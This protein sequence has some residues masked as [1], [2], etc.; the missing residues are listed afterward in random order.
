[1]PKETLHYS[2]LLPD[3]VRDSAR[4]RLALT[5]RSAHPDKNNE[6][7]EFLGD[8]VLGLAVADW[9]YRNHPEWSEGDM[10]RI[11]STL[12]NREALNAVGQRTGLIDHI[13]VSGSMTDEQSPI[14]SRVVASAVEAVIGAVYLECGERQARD[15][16]LAW[17]APLLEAVPDDPE[18]AKDP[19]TRLQERLQ[20]QH[21]KRPVYRTLLSPASGGN[22]TGFL[23]ECSS[24]TIKTVGFGAT[25]RDAE[26]AAASEMLS[27]AELA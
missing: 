16:V 22:A 3:S 19:K 2:R 25:K 26:L 8:A 12:V 13:H 6:R 15:F 7:L 11:R 5:H 4:L 23:V 14:S 24:G 10:S 18:Q 21:R 9:L 17:L 1:M 20:M 27:H